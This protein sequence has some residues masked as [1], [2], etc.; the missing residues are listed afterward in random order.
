MAHSFNQLLTMQGRADK[1][2][3]NFQRGYNRRFEFAHLST[4]VK[5]NHAQIFVID[6]KRHKHRTLGKFTGN[7]GVIQW[8]DIAMTDVHTAAGSQL[9]TE[10]IRLAYVPDA[11]NIGEFFGDAIGQPFAPDHQ[12]PLIAGSDFSQCQHGAIHAGCFAEFTQYL[13]HGRH[14]VRRLEKNTTD[15]RRCRP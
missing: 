6:Q 12:P 2:G 8:L 3:G 14:Y 7:A 4:I 5:A 9:R 11:R 13:R 15:T 1:A 10:T